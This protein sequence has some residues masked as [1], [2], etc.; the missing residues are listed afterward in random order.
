MNFIGILKAVLTIGG[1]GLIIGLFLGIANKVF[2]VEV[3]ENEEKIRELLPG[4]NCGGCG[5]AGCDALASAIVNKEAEVSACPVGGVAVADAIAKLLGTEN[6]AVKM[7]AFV[8]CSGTCDKAFDKYIYSGSK[9]CKEALDVTGEGAKSCTY[10]CLGLG[11]C[12]SACDF[13]AIHIED[14]I[15]V[16]DKEKC[17]GCGKC[18]IECPKCIIEKIPYKSYYVVACNSNDRGIDVKKVCNAGCIGCGFC[19]KNCPTD[20]I[21]VVDSLSRIEQ[22]K[23]VGC[24]LCRDMCPTK[25][26]REIEA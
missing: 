16:V 2:S 12:I 24:G 5:Y 10:G 19:T 13:D 8:R 22:S 20:A 4:N 14:G 7:V 1:T 9:S 3:D 15:A 6:T 11:S 26:I 25:I 23:C 18:V 21:E 17:V